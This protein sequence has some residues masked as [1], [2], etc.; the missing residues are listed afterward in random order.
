MDKSLITFSGYKNNSSALRNLP[1]VKIYVFSALIAAFGSALVIFLGIKS[2]FV[3]VS[4]IAFYCFLRYK[5]SLLYFFLAIMPIMISISEGAIISIISYGIALM[6]LASWI[7]RKLISSD[8]HIAISQKLTIFILVFMFFCLISVLQNGVNRAELYAIVRLL[9]FFGLVLALYDM[10]QWKDTDKIFVAMSLPLI[11]ASYYIISIYLNAG[12]V[13]AAL[14]LFR[15]KATGFIPN[16]NSLG[17]LLILVVAYWIAL[18]IWS[19]KRPIRIISWVLALLFSTSLI[20]TNS[21]SAIFGFMIMVFLFSIWTKKIK[22]LIAVVFIII[23]ILVFN[24]AARNLIG[25]AF[26]VDRGSSS[27][28]IIW[29]NTTD[30]IKKNF[31]L[32]VGI[33]NYGNEYDVYYA[34]GWERGFF[35]RMSHAHN[36]ILSKMA[37]LGIAGLLLALAMYYMPIRSGLNVLKNL[38]SP[39]DKVVVYSIIATIGALFARSIFEAGGILQEARLHGDITFWIL[40]VL[41]LKSE[42]YLIK[43]SSGI[44]AKS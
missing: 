8:K 37:E 17:H 4:P 9:I 22:Q 41:L 27:R 12:S 13:V 35:G 40:F 19:E 42:A 3:T 11:V 30:M 7:F 18:S 1:T 20:L 33:G 26:R 43:S 6:I 38:K 15:Y 23:A 14:S 24:P 10:L 32:G 28:E 5:N 29:A 34:T 2:L 39:K 16:A 21:R 36:H 31:W 25:I 44:L